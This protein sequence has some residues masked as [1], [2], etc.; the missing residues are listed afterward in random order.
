MSPVN[1]AYKKANLAAA[2]HRIAMAM[3]AAQELPYLTASAWEAEQ[4]EYQPTVAVLKHISA[5]QHAMFGHSTAGSQTVC[6][7]KL[8]CSKAWNHC[9]QSPPLPPLRV[10]HSPSPSWL[11]LSSVQDGIGSMELMS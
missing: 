9:H 6:H 10:W 11:C 3:L 7:A 5:H 4:P 8:T 1:D 2:K